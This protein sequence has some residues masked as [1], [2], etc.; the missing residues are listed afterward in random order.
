M[1]GLSAHP[2][3]LRELYVHSRG[4]NLIVQTPSPQRSAPQGECRAHLRKETDLN[5]LLSLQRL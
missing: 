2:A 3:F 4:V 1:L 5:H